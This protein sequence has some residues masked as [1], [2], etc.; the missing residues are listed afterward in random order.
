MTW[1]SRPP[2]HPI[3]AIQGAL[4]DL[5]G[6]AVVRAPSCRASPAT[7]ASRH[8][9]PPPSRHRPPRARGLHRL[10]PQPRRPRASRGSL[11]DDMDR[12]R[13][14]Q[15]RA[16]ALGAHLLLAQGRALPGAMRDVPH[17]QPHAGVRAGER[18][19]RARQRE[20]R[21]LPRARR[22]PAHRAVH[23]GSRRGGVAAR[24]RRAEEPAPRGRAV[25]PR[26]QAP[27][28]HPA[29]ARRDHHVPDRRGGARRPERAGKTVPRR[30]GHAPSGGGAG[31]RGG[32][33]DRAHDRPRVRARRMRRADPRPRR[34]VARR[35]L[36][37]QRG[38]GGAGDA[39]GVDPHRD[40]DRA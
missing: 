25:R 1:T 4:S 9:R 22:V 24:V 23:G 3:P 6:I 40:R 33:G 26:A 10:A 7:A 16:P 30:A 27:D 8:V 19:A 35:P 2:G 11:L 14:L 13:D 31:R 21:P 29:A 39:P 15:P 38:G 36:G 34:G 20:G 37:V 32:G 5:A 18:A 28:P 12:G 17:A